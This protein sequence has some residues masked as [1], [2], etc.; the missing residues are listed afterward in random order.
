MMDDERVMRDPN[1]CDRCGMIGG[2]APGCWLLKKHIM[3]ELDIG[4]AGME[5]AYGV[6]SAL[7]DLGREL[8]ISGF[9]RTPKPI[10][11]YL[12]VVIGNWHFAGE[13]KDPE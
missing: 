5:T 10:K 8:R 9:T 1:Y 11:N 12:G 6:G 2:H 13:G 3:I 4:G 7:M